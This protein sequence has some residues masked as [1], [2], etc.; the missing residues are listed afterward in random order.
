MSYG[1]IS[2]R[3]MEKRTAHEGSR[4]APAEHLVRGSLGTRM[5]THQETRRYFGA[6][7]LGLIVGLIWCND[8]VLLDA[9]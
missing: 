7:F 3:L 5:L 2:R 1:T 4:E 6:D 8:M 9:D